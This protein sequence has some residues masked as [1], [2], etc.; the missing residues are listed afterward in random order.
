MKLSYTLKNSEHF[1]N[2]KEMLKVH[3]N[4]SDRLLLKLKKGNKICVNGTPS[5]LHTILKSGDLVEIYIDFEEDNWNIVPVN[6]KL[7]IVYEDEAYI[8]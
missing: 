7:D 4:I 6:M 8:V 5:P 3:F 1:D 2:L